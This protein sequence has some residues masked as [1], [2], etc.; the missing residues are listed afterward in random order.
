MVDIKQKHINRVKGRLADGTVVEYHSI[1]GEKNSR[2]WKSTDDTEI[3]SAEYISAYQTATRRRTSSGSFGDVISEYLSSGEFRKLATRT[4]LDYQKWLDRIRNQFGS[5]P[6]EVIDDPRIRQAAMK[7]RDQWSGKNAQY[8]WT[9]LR[10]VVSWGYDRGHFRNHHLRGGGRVYKSDR[11]DIIW[12]EAEVVT[13][14]TT[15]LAHMGKAIRAAVETGLRPGDLVRLAKSHF[16]DTANGK[17]IRIKTKKTGAMVTIPVTLKM[18]GVLAAASDELILTNAN[19]LQWSEQWLSKVIGKARQA[20]GL[21]DD[22]RLYDAR[23]SAATRLVLA[24]ATIHE[25]AQHMGW[26]VKTA[27]NMVEKYAALDP[28]LADSVRAKLSIYV[29][30]NGVESAK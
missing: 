21:R 2:F 11:S 5:A 10:L 26:S 12:T 8:A 13:V 24:G 3:G 25:I 1:R 22:L 14:E 19:G 6:V 30:E 18:A 20:A 9:V 4:Q 23:G 15:A 17:Q 27:S 29:D 16:E 7:W 28:A